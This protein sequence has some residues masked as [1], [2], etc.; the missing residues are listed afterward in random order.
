MSAFVVRKAHDLLAGGHISEQPAPRVFD[1]QGSEGHTY[2]VVVSGDLTPDFC[3][4]P[5]VVQCSHMLAAQ[6]L[7]RTG[8]SP[9]D[10][11]RVAA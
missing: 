3:S 10:L 2:K 4:C 1:I 8:Q 5:A 9:A 6:H 11:V 7:V